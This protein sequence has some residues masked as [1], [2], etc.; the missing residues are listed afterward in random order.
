MIDDLRY[1]NAVI[2]CMDVEKY[3]DSNGDGI[4]DF[5]G[6]ASRLD[7]LAGLGVTCIWPSVLAMRYGVQRSVAL[8]RTQ[9]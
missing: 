2:Y 9:L 6:L 4:G 8:H 5:A 7:Y 1:K 3:V